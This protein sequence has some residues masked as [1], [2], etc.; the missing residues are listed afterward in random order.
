MGDRNL[1]W[2]VELAL[3]L[4]ALLW[5]AVGCGL[6]DSAAQAPSAAYAIQN[7]GSD[8]LVNLALAWAEAYMR[9]HPEMRMY[10]SAQAS[11]RFTNVSEPLF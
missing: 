7:K 1:A 11:A 9:L 5:L 2:R 6:R 3:L 10:A 8:T 4:L